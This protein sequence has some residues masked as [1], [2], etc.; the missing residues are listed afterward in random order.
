MVTGI[1]AWIAVTCIV[2]F[3]QTTIMRIVK[4]QGYNQGTMD[5]AKHWIAAINKVKVPNWQSLP[6]NPNAT[7]PE[8]QKRTSVRSTSSRKTSL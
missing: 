3:V 8:G 7:D 1:I 6:A 5:E 4:L 2:V